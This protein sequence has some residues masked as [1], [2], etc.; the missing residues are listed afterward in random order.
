MTALHLGIFTTDE[1]LVIRTWDDWMADTTAIQSVDALHRPLADVLPDVESRGLLPVLHDVLAR[2]TVAVLAPALHHYLFSCAPAAPV[3]GFDR[4]QQHVVIGPLRENNR[5]LG[6]IVTVEDVTARMEHERQLADERRRGSTQDVA[7][8]T[9]QLAEDDWRVRAEAVSSLSSGGAAVVDALIRT[10]RSQHEN[11]NVL[12]SALDLLAVS[13][14]DV[15]DPLVA[16]LDDQ[17]VNLRIQAALIL[18]E[19]RDR[20]AIP[21]LIARLEDPDVN[22]RF[23]AIEAL[24]RLNAT[25]ACEALAGVAEQRDFFLSFPAIQALGRLGNSSVASRLVPLLADE[26]LRAPAIEALGELGDEDV[27]EPL[28][29]MLDIPE[30]P[31]E[32]I[33][34]ALAGLY[35]RYESEHGAGDLIAALVRRS[36]SATS[37]QRIL[38]T[39]QRAGPDRLA[40]LAR[41]LGW[42]DGEAVQRALTRLLGYD[43]VRTQVVEALVRNGRGVVAPLI[44][45]LRAEDLETRQAAAVALGR[46]GD[47]RATTALVAALAERELAVPAALALASIGDPRAFE[48]LIGLVGDSDAAIRQAAIAALNSIGHPELPARTADMLDGADPVT[49]ES[50][51]K[52]AGYFGY[53]ECLDRVLACCDDVSVS[54][55]RTAAEQLPYFDDRRAGDRLRG[56][57]ADR[58]PSVRAAV[59]QALA[60]AEDP[61][62]TD[63][64]S[65][66][67]SDPDPW[68]RFVSL[69]SIAAIRASSALPAVMACLQNDPAPHVRLNAIEVVGA[70]APPGALE[71]LEPLVHSANDDVARSAVAALG[72][73]N[74]PEA[75]AILRQEMKAEL[76]WRRVAAID[77]LAG[78][79]DADVPAILQMAAAADPDADVATA[80]V[81]ALA[82]A[83]ATED[84][85]SEDATHA[86]IALTAEPSRRQAA[87]AAIGALPLRRL[88]VIANGLLHSDHDVRSAIVA[89]LGR[90][91]QPAASQILESALSDGSPAVRLTAVMELRQLGGRASQRKLLA[92]ARTDPDHGVRRAAMLAVARADNAGVIDAAGAQ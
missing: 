82:A 74:R 47:E 15:I 46:I 55:R 88:P 65:G 78:R 83:A 11:L 31:T 52:I 7:S 48:P 37:T 10:L 92:L 23:H 81:A 43:T 90:M 13:D 12:S 21:A 1:R 41:V 54:V 66:L 60:R 30:A 61:S 24:G 25:E 70:L 59:A 33:T 28:V 9:R 18:G 49:R 84:L 50:A 35:D 72:K 3:R 22:V 27:A 76:S 44:E 69:K 53:S 67:L 38:D 5:I 62:R 86:L 68:V 14:L 91:R 77:A 57:V 80:S 64:L 26:M 73:V 51:L 79:I 40:G 63:A 58:D 71:I 16:C 45:Q 20:R 19:R 2:G 87:I 34:D 17:D 4:M 39:V 8:L 32:V 29:R 85:R 56:M 75:L 6:L 42:L 36:I 89:A